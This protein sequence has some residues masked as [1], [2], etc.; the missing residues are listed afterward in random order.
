MFGTEKPVCVTP[1]SILSVT[2]GELP[3]KEESL[4]VIPFCDG[5]VKS[6]FTL[7]EADKSTSLINDF[8]L[9]LS[10]LCLKH[11]HSLRKHEEYTLLPRR[12]G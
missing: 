12:F 2:T 4:A 7:P 10:L 9:R 8:F 3:R 6:A 5:T 1:S 11:C